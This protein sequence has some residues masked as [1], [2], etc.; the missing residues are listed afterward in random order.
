MQP[1]VRLRLGKPGSRDTMRRALSM[2]DGWQAELG[3]MTDIFVQEAERAAQA[4]RISEPAHYAELS[5]TLEALSLAYLAISHLPKPVSSFG[6]LRSLDLHRN[7]LLELPLELTLLP[8]LSHLDCSYNSITSLPSCFEALT[9]LSSL[10]LS[11]NRLRVLPASL[12][13]RLTNLTSLNAS[14]NE[15]VCF[16]ELHLELFENDDDDDDNHNHNASTQTSSPVQSQLH[17]VLQQQQHELQQ[18]HQQHQRQELAADSPRQ[19]RHSQSETLWF[20]MTLGAQLEE[21][22]LSFNQIAAIPPKLFSKLGG[23]LR[24]LNLTANTDMAHCWRCL[25]VLT[26]LESLECGFT[27]ATT[28]ACYAIAQLSCLTQLDLRNNRIT[29]LPPSM[30]L[31]LTRLTHLNLSANRL[32]HLPS[33]VQLLASLVHLD[34]SSNLL[35]LLPPTIV[36]LPRLQFLLYHQNHNLQSPPE[37]IRK[38]GTLNPPTL[39]RTREKES[40]PLQTRLTLRTIQASNQCSST[41]AASCRVSSTTNGS[42]YVV[43]G[44]PDSLYLSRSLTM[45]YATRRQ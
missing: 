25:P 26:R 37:H 10:D 7:E 1:S 45:T 19:T 27:N 42:S 20:S 13:R 40:A 34:V 41:T 36:K 30:C 24:K 15:I 32:T 4:A 23:S 44:S 28:D 12:V 43:I 33:S 3:Y 38:A 39:T 2:R 11:N 16:D 18:Q 31:A 17:L 22:D 29:D 5:A 9:A 6:Q 14:Q 35:R 8:N 21:L